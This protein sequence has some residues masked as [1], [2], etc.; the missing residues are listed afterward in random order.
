MSSSSVFLSGPQYVLG[1]IATHHT[2]TPDLKARAGEL[3]VPY[4]PELWGWGHVHR[5]HKSLEDLAVEAG[6][7]TLR[8]AG[9]DP[10]SVDA[11]VLCCTSFPG[12]PDSHGSFVRT[13]A[14]GLGTR[15]TEFLG[16]TL[17][18]CTNLLAGLRVAEAFVA[19]GIHRRVLVV[20]TDRVTVEAER[21][22]KFALF[23]D[24]AAGVL[25][26]D[27]EGEYEIVASAAAHELKDLDWSN[28]IS[29]DLSR[30]VNTQLMKR[31]SIGI[32]QV[33]ILMHANIF[34]AIVV[35]KELQAGFTAAQLYT[36]NIARVGH[37]F[38]ADPIINLT[39]LAAAGRLRDDGHYLLAA[40]VPGVRYGVLLRKQTR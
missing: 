11:L 21:L 18:R 35:M 30:R 24:G 8:A 29:P 14:E 16:I 19:A 36:D 12:G 1:E 3:G 40:S 33:D 10:S 20:T 7:A 5:S 25:V 37:C 4:A 34:E 13:I 28:Q 32:D 26:S 15:E 27:T 23:S 2:E 6:E 31:A 38:A 22:A 17:D 9:V 39:D